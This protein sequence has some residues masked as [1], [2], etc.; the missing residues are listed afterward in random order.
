MFEMNYEYQMFC[1][2]IVAP[3]TTSM[4]EMVDY[5]TWLIGSPLAYD[6]LNTAE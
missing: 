6:T 5:V 4:E 2:D 3:F 1:S